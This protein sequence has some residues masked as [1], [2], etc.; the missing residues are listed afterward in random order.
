MNP[1]CQ[2]G[3]LAVTT[4]RKERGLPFKM[5][6][7]EARRVKNEKEEVSK[8]KSREGR[9]VEKNKT[10]RVEMNTSL[11]KSSFFF[12]LSAIEE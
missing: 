8:C 1:E 4:K 3:K 6:Q 9:W 11:M 2:E 5:K 10:L 12:F 7:G